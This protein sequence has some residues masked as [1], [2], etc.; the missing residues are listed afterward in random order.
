VIAAQPDPMLIRLVYVSV[1][2]PGLTHDDVDALVA[3][4]HRSN[5][6]RGITGLMALDDGRVCQILEG[7]GVEVL[8]LFA[9]IRT[10]KRHRDVIDLATTFID[11]R[12]FGEWG[13]AR[14]RMVD[15]VTLAFTI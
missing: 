4:S 14:R 3:H 15:V 5:V 9:K 12:H 2:S 1:L 11:R 6:R 10:D 13:M 8:Q 7:P